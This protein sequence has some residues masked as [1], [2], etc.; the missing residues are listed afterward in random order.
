MTAT[1]WLELETNFA[2]EGVTIA[3]VNDAPDAVNDTLLDGN[4]DTTSAV[5]NA[6]MLSNDTDVDGDTLTITAIDGTALVGGV[7]TIAV[8]NGTVTVDVV[9]PPES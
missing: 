7:Q 5:L 3:A 8:T 2:P 1:T 6:N 4:E 9:T